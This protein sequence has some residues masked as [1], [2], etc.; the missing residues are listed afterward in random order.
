MERAELAL[1][2]RVAA[3]AQ[4]ENRKGFVG[5]F[6]LVL[7]PIDGMD[8]RQNVSARSQPQLDHL[9]RDSLRGFCIGK[10]AEREN[11]FVSH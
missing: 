5:G 6:D 3:R 7:P 10:R 1:K 4:L 8:L 2:F 9:A 11:N